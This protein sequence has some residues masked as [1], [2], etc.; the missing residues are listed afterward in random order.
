MPDVFNYST[1]DYHDWLTLHAR[2]LADR[3]RML[4]AERRARRG[5]RPRAAKLLLD[6]ID[7]LART[8]WL[9]S[10]VESGATEA[11]L[12][13]PRREAANVD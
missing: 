9:L 7:E 8:Q 2:Q 6:S 11:E 3:I 4:K 13:R 12:T 5:L 1:R 10:R